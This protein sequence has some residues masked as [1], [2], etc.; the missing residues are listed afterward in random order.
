MS[1]VHTPWKMS[2]SRIILASLPSF[3]QKYQNWW[4]FDEVLTKTILHSFFRHGVHLKWACSDM[5]LDSIAKS[6]D[7][8]S[9]PSVVILQMVIIFVLHNY[10][11]VRLPGRPHTTWL[12][13]VWD[14]TEL[15][16]DACSC[17]SD[18]TK[19][20]AVA[21][22]ALKSFIRIHFIHYRYTIMFVKQSY[23]LCS[24]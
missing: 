21:T 23:N 24:N 15:L 13:E 9:S 16:S 10:S 5:S 2:T 20:R 18:R 6:R 19:W 3:C 14:D 1:A 4:K 11:V 7:P 8:A 22:E 12:H 17:A